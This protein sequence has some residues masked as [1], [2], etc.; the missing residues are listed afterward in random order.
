VRYLTNVSAKK[1]FREMGNGN[2]PIHA[3]RAD[4]QHS[5]WSLKPKA[6]MMTESELQA[7][8]TREVLAR[9]ARA[10]IYLSEPRCQQLAHMLRAAAA[11]IACDERVNHDA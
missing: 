9:L 8:E 10:R 2:G 11:R 7:Q 3:G 6:I 1:L 4:V 5:S